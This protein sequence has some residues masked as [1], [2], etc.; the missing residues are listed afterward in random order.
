MSN[1]NHYVRQLRP[2][3]ESYIDPVDRIQDLFMVAEGGQGGLYYETKV[4][5][6][7]MD[8]QK[9]RPGKFFS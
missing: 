3:T 2:R 4:F 8:Y 6:I 9:T 5:G 1:L 7:M